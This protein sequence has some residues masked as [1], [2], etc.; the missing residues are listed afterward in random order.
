MLILT[1]LGFAKLN[2]EV[3]TIQNRKEFASPPVPFFAYAF[4]NLFIIYYLKMIS[5]PFRW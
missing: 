3:S 1:N 4:Y 5:L 2:Y